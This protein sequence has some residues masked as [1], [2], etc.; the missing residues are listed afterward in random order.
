M[1]RARWPR[2]SG[3]PAPRVGPALLTG[4]LPQASGIFQLRLTTAG[5]THWPH[6]ISQTWPGLTPQ[7]ASVLPSSLPGRSPDRWQSPSPASSEGPGGTG[8]EKWSQLRAVSCHSS[9]RQHIP[10]LLSCL[11]TQRGLLSMPTL[12]SLDHSPWDPPPH[13]HPCYVHLGCSLPL[14]MSP[15]NLKHSPFPHPW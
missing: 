8:L 9:R 7:H 6:Q 12:G 2:F 4:S 14:P 13:P 10:H 3:C 15:L 1:G 5:C 11:G